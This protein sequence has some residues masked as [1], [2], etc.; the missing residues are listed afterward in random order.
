MSDAYTYISK[1]TGT[2]YT[3]VNTIGGKEQYDQSNILYDDPSTY[4][5]GTNPNAY[6]NIAKPQN[7]TVRAGR[8]SGLLIPLTVATS[9][10]GTAWKTINKPSN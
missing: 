1:P 9:V 10:M 6:T 2:P 3:N 5:D 8:A 7:P 4:Y